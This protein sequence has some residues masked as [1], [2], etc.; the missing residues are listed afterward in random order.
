MGFKISEE[1]GD[2][3]EKYNPFSLF[4]I[5]ILL[6]LSEDALFK[7]MSMFMQPEKKF[8]DVKTLPIPANKENR[9]ME[10]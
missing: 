2:D 5:L 4:L 7:L 8:N 9:I 10:T 6:I 3:K 1:D